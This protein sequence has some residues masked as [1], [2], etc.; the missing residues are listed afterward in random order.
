MTGFG[1]GAAPLDGG[2]INVE[3]RAVNGRFLDVRVRLPQ[4]LTDLTA[5]VDAEAR[6]WLS[7]GRCDI[8]IRTEGNVFPGPTIDKERARAAYRALVE[9]KDEITPGADVPFAMLSAL[10]DLFVPAR[11]SSLTAA[12]KAVR[13]A[14][15]AALDDLDLM[16]KKEGRAIAEDLSRRLDLVRELMNGIAARAPELVQAQA[17]R[18]RERLA[19]ISAIVADAPSPG[20]GRELSLDSARL[21]QEIVLLLER[22]DISEELTRLASHVEQMGAY[23]PDDE[24]LGRKLDFLLQEMAREI[25]TIGAKSQ[26]LRIA[27]LVIEL[28][29]ETER[30][31]EQVQNVE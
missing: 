30:M 8:G 18:L 7:R 4:E 31:R 26:D 21:E 28:K 19:R 9:L 27:H 22:S 1:V 17:R 25:N 23:L 24:P 3:I 13:T 29:A 16:R 14:L 5:M 6:K 2:R 10:P 20:E 12:E 15:A 11:S